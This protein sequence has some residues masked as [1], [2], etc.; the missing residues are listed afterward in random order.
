MQK[1]LSANQTDKLILIVRYCTKRIRDVRIPGESRPGSKQKWQTEK[2]VIK[3]RGAAC[4]G[5]C[6]WRKPIRVL[7]VQDS[8]DRS[9]VKLFRT[10]TPPQGVCEN[11]VNALVLLANQREV[12]I[13]T[14]NSQRADWFLLSC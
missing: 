1:W 10:H 14:E 3:K 8:T 13:E 2:E 7:F 9:Q 12:G 5:Q 6:D 4:C 11:L